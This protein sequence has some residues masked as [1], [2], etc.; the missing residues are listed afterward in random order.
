VEIY[1]LGGFVLTLLYEVPRTTSDLDYIS[2]VPNA[3]SEEL[4]RMGG[5]GSNS[6]NKHKV[7]FQYVGI[8]DLPDD[9]ESRLTTLNLGLSR[10]T[11]KILDAYDGLHG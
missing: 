6:A 11:V 1:C 7:H 2:A 5:A 4:M 9:D 10:L 3:A 8:A